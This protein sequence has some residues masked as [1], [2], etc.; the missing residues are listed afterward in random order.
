M[1]LKS[2]ILVVKVLSLE[3]ANEAGV[4]LDFLS[5]VFFRPEE[6]QCK[7]VFSTFSE[8]VH[9]RSANVSMI[10]PKMRLRTMMMTTKKK[11]MS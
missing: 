8:L 1:Y 9:L 10:T 5:V 3:A 7:L 2:N 11:R 6:K 4:F